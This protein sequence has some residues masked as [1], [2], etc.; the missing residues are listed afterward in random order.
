MPLNVRCIVSDNI[1]YTNNI[2]SPFCTED[3]YQ[4]LIFLTLKLNKL[5]EEAHVE[6]DMLDN[7]LH[8]TGLLFGR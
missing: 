6:K 1:E 7:P 5:A 8:D 4:R 3:S 2:F